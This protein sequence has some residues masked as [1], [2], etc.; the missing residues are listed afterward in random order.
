MSFDKELKSTAK[1]LRLYSK[2]QNNSQEASEVEQH[3]KNKNISSDLRK[4]ICIAVA[5]F[6]LEIN[7]IQHTMSKCFA[8]MFDAAHA[9]MCDH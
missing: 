7:N 1:S 3:E 4:M 6:K 5:V 2:G 9:C 8:K